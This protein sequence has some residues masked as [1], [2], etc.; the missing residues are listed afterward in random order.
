MIILGNQLINQ[1]LTLVSLSIDSI[2]SRTKNN[3]D[4]E[5]MGYFPRGRPTKNRRKSMSLWREETGL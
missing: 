5:Q 1:D 3:R 4:Y 2:G